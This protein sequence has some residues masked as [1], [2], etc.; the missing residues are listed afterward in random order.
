M[1]LFSKSPEKK[2]IKARTKYRDCIDEL[3][4]LSILAPDRK[5]KRLEHKRNKQGAIIATLKETYKNPN[6][7]YSSPTPHTKNTTVTV[8]YIKN[9]VNV[10]KSPKNKK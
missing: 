10:N 6:P 1:G 3:N 4:N 5:R 9:Q 7:S 8:S 2:M